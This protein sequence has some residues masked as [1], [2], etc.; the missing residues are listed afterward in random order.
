MIAESTL[1]AARAGEN[2]A[3]IDCDRSPLFGGLRCLACFQQRA[4]DRSNGKHGCPRH[5]PSVVCY[6]QCACRCEGC[7]GIEKKRRVR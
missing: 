6:N 2:V 3:C 1:N 7:G 5:E 4:K